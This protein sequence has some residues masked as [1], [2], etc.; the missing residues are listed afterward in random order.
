FEVVGL[1][2]LRDRFLEVT[3]IVE[4]HPPVEMLLGLGGLV[5][6]R[7]GRGQGDNDDGCGDGGASHGTRTISGPP[8]ARQPWG[9]VSDAEESIHRLP[10]GGGRLRPMLRAVAR[11]MGVY[12]GRRLDLLQRH[13][14]GAGA[15]RIDGDR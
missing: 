4:L 2:E 5:G 8:A 1:L 13:L 7:G 14:Q 12:L 3:E 11:S 10:W 15:A 9:S 6:M